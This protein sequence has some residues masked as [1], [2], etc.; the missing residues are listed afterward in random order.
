M[1]EI[2]S[3]TKL[4]VLIV[5]DDYIVIKGLRKL[6]NWEKL[7]MEVIAIATNGEEA[8][9]KMKT[10]P[11]DVVIT[12]VNMPKLNGIEFV[13]EARKIQSDFQL[14]FISGYQSFDYVKS[15]MDLGAVNYILKPIDKVEIMDILESVSTK[16]KELKKDKH[17]LNMNHKM[18]LKDWLNRV[19]SS[20]EPL[21]TLEGVKID[22]LY[23]LIEIKD[24][25]IE[26]IREV[27]ENS[28]DFIIV[29]VFDKFL[30]LLSLNDI[31]PTMV[32]NVYDGAICIKQIQ[33]A[34]S[35]L[36]LKTHFSE[37]KNGMKNYRFYYSKASGLNGSFESLKDY[38]SN[39]P[40]NELNKEDIIKLS[41]LTKRIYKAIS[42]YQVSELLVRFEEFISLIYFLKIPYVDAV[43]YFQSIVMFYFS[44]NKTTDYQIYKIVQELGQDTSFDA[45]IKLMRQ[46]ISE[47]TD[48]NN[49]ITLSSTVQEV[50]K[51]VHDN[52][53]E[54]ISLKQLSEELHINVM[55]LG[56]LFKKEVG[57]SLS[58]Y[59]NYYRIEQAK[60]L[61]TQTNLTVAEI[62]FKVG[63]QNQAYFYRVF[64]SSENKSPKEYRNEYLDQIKDNLTIE[65]YNTGL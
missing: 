25:S 28:S 43:Q 47:K 56:Q 63:Y 32:E 18:I 35:Y 17:L 45:K 23:Y 4:N 21:D 48:N 58:K 27:I 29:D 5:D 9:H 37:L 26:T 16:V 12:D 64:K 7:D 8:L 42:N 15:G 53:C 3:C 57:M 59:L 51:Q 40:D 54:D 19:D 46:T 1:Y 34:T 44:K 10:L 14:I 39:S 50:I 30:L 20:L 62:G 6:I 33:R 11:V 49:K 52:Y 38:L 31:Q 61:L 22:Y 13:K 2:A 36:E 55:Y 41:Q 24:H 65:H 60:T